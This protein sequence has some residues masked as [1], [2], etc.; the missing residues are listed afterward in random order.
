M[1]R[2]TI[3]AFRYPPS[4]KGRPQVLLIGNGLERTEGQPDWDALLDA[5]VCPGRAP[6]TQAEREAL[7]FPLLY[8]LLSTPDPAPA[9]LE[10]EDVTA[11]EQRL[12]K[13]LALLESRSNPL[14]D[15]LPQLGADHILSTNYSYCL[16]KAFYR[17]L[18]FSYGAA[19]SG[20]RFSL[21]PPEEAKR[22]LSYRLHTGY[23]AKNAD[24]SPVGLWHIHGETTVPRG[25]VVGHDRYGRLL[26]RMVRV[27]GSETVHSLETEARPFRSWPELFLFGDVYVLGQGFALCEHDLWWLLRRKQR[28]RYADGTVYFYDNEDPAQPKTALRN[29]LLLAHG[30]RLNPDLD[31]VPGDY[32]AFY[33]AALDRIGAQIRDSRV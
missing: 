18:D 15:R 3:S 33:H 22:E 8:Q 6:L 9:R 7:P 11:E 14:L 24:R 31:R 5:L 20:K 21:L 19:R 10:P 1:R 25:V 17:R 4:G 23:L 32:A 16:E 12:A 29:R 26:S 2:N 13:A 28:E 27:C 30:V